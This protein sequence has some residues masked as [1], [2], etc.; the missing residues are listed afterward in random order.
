MNKTSVPEKAIEHTPG[1]WAVEH[2]INDF[3][4]VVTRDGRAPA[5]LC[6]YIERAAD[7]DL[8]AAAPD[9]L[10][11]L[12]KIRGALACSCK[13][14]PLVDGPVPCPTCQISAVIAKAEG[15]AW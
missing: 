1:P 12:K 15:G 13:L 5:R 7:A 14:Q 9:M 11:M 8:I 10:A 2:G 6:G 3:D 4:I